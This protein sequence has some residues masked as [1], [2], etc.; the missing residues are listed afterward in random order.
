MGDDSNETLVVNIFWALVIGIG[1]ASLSGCGVGLPAPFQRPLE[2]RALEA[3]AVTVEVWANDAELPEFGERCVEERA[4]LAVATPSA[5]D[6]LDACGRCAAAPAGTTCLA[7]YGPGACRWG[8]AASCFIYGRER[9]TQ[10][11]AAHRDRTPVLVV[12]PRFAG[13]PAHAV[14]HETM[15]WLSACTGHVDELNELGGRAWP[16]YDANH[17][18]DRLWSPGGVLPRARGRL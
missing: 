12:A 8:C 6:F 16:Q 9:W 13:D 1:L 7:H 5:D 4:A 15:H 2:G 17:A 18:D 11:V 14:A 3:V 10:T